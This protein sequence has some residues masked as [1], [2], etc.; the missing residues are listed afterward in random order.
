MRAR[1]PGERPSPR[2]LRVAHQAA[3][4]LLGYPD[5]VLLGQLPLL[6]GAAASLPRPV[7]APLATFV[8]GLAAVPLGVAQARYVD[9]FDLT[10]RCCPFL[11][12]Y[13]YGDTRKRGMA[14]LRFS[15]A[16]RA[17]GRQPPDGELPDH[18]AV[19]LE[20]SAVVDPAAGMRLLR[21]HRVGLELLRLA[22]HETGSPYRE[23]LDAVSATLPDPSPRDRDA[24]LRLAAAGPPVEDVGLDPTVPDLPAAAPAGPGRDPYAL[25]DPTGG[26]R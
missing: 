18:L 16:Y 10:R 4:L 5:E 14:L 12:Y 15:H 11:T 8:D 23:V 26:R 2:Q 1:R 13:S 9:T 3:S 24:V 21:E 25:P 20:F 6:A 17:A 22:L 19:V 7:G